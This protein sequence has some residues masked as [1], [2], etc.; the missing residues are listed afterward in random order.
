MKK[1]FVNIENKNI[2]IQTGNQEKIDRKLIFK[3][4]D[5]VFY[6]AKG[7]IFIKTKDN[8]YHKIIRCANCQVGI[9]IIKYIWQLGCRFTGQ[10]NTFNDFRNEWL[11]YFVGNN[12]DT[13]DGVFDYTY[14]IHPILCR[15]IMIQNYALHTIYCL[16]DLTKPIHVIDSKLFV[17]TEEEYNNLKNKI[18]NNKDFIDKLIKYYK[19]NNKDIYFLDDDY[20]NKSIEN[21]YKIT[22]NQND[23]V[24]E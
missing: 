24:R 8:Q 19:E 15:K 4:R 12:N 13:E 5:G 10:Y 16:S 21:Y 2:I 9:N 22:T 1:Q 6:I 7:Y 14:K 17:K 20:D 11:N 23:L 18:A 3:S